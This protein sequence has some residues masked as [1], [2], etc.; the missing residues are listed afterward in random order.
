MVFYIYEYNRVIENRRYLNLI[1]EALEL[2]LC[3]CVYVVVISNQLIG[4]VVGNGKSKD[5]SNMKYIWKVK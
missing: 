1:I 3:T 4:G 5:S 2:S